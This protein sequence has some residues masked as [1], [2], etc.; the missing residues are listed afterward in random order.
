MLILKGQGQF[1]L[2]VSH[3]FIQLKCNLK[4]KQFYGE[5]LIKCKLIGSPTNPVDLELRSNLK[6]VGI[7]SPAM[8]MMTA[9]CKS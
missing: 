9:K 4:T 5:T 3:I 8:N 1:C 7:V 2:R 6:K